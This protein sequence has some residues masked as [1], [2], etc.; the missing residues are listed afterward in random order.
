MSDKEPIQQIVSHMEFQQLLLKDAYWTVKLSV[1]AGIQIIYP[2]YHLRFVLNEEPY[3]RQIKQAQ[4]NVVAVQNDPDLF[5]ENVKNAEDAVK[6][7]EESLDHARKNIPTI[8]FE[9]T[10]EKAEQKMGGT[11]LTMHID[12]A[13][14]QVIDEH[15]KYLMPYNKKDDPTYKVELTYDNEEEA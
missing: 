12:S 5:E 10:V 11:E 4:A 1:K 2:K 9:A 7:A 8:E 6:E 15:K 13:D 3:E 14:V